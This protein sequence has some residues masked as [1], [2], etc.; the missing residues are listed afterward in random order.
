MTI[1][2]RTIFLNLWLAI[3]PFSLT[4]EDARVETVEGFIHPESS[5]SVREILESEGYRILRSNGET[6]CEIWLRDSIPTQ[7]NSDVLG[8]IYPQLAKSIFVGV[9]TFPKE[10][11]D[12]RGQSIKA[13]T[14]T[15]RYELLPE[16]GN[17]MGA[18][19]TRDFLL[20][21]PVAIDSVVEAI[22]DFEALTNL[23]TRAS[24]TNHPASFNMVY[25][26]SEENLPFVLE[27]FEGHIIFTGKFRTHSGK[28]LVF[29]LTLEGE[30][31]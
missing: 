24:E 1:N 31:E 29:A 14:Y 8:A 18:A 28:P 11:S 6:L 12:C 23:S 3:I 27:T 22:Y 17:H 20:L 9:L 19:P 30:T 7:I 16:D 25:P 5:E 15:L 2:R 10:G 4:G 13:G 26:E 21:T